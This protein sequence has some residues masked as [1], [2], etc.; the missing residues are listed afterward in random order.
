MERF[1]QVRGGLALQ[2][3]RRF[4]SS[5]SDFGAE[6]E[7]RRLTN[8]GEDIGRL[9][10][11]RPARRA[12][13]HHGHSRGGRF[14][15]CVRTQRRHRARRGS[16]GLPR[17]H[18]AAV[19]LGAAG[20]RLPDRGAPRA[21]G[22]AVPRDV[23]RQGLPPSRTGG[24]HPARDQGPLC[25]RG[26]SRGPDPAQPGR[27]TGRMRGRHTGR[28]RRGRSVRGE[29]G[30]GPARGRRGDDHR[31]V[32]AADRLRHPAPRHQ[33]R[34]RTR[35]VRR[36]GQ[37]HLPASS[38]PLAANGPSACRSTPSWRGRSRPPGS[39]PTT[40]S[41]TPSPPGAVPTGIASARPS[42]PPTVPSP[43]S[44]TGPGR[45]SARC[46]SSI[47][48]C[49]TEP[50]RR[51]RRAVVHDPVRPRLAAHRVDGAAAGPSPGARHAAD[52][53][54]VPGRPTTTRAPRRSRA[55]SCTRSAS[56]PHR[57]L[58]RPAARVYYG[59][60]R[61]HAAVRDAARR[62]A[63]V[64][65]C[66]RRAWPSCCRTPTR[67]WTGSSSYGDRD[68]DGFVEYQRDDRPRA[69]QPGLE[70]LLGRVTFADGTAR[71]TPRSRCA[72]VQGYVY[73]AYV[74]RAHF[75]RRGRRQRDGAQRWVGRAARLREAFNERLLAAGPGLVRPRPRRR[76]A[77]DRRARLQ[78]GPLPVDRDRRRGQGA[79]RSPSACS[80]RRCSPAGACAR[81][82]P[83]MG[84][85]NP[86]SYHNG[87]VWPH[88]N[89][90]IAAGLMRYGFVEEAQR[91][92][93]GLLDAADALRRPAARAV[94]R[95]RPGRVRRAGAVSHLV[96]SPGV[97]RGQ[98]HPAAADPAPLRPVHSR[99]PGVARP[100]RAGEPA[101]HGAPAGGLPGHDRRRRG[102]RRRRRAAGR[103]RR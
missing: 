89:A 16:G 90:L 22:R 78:H 69:G 77:P 6:E 12:G 99:R 27:R 45:I 28:L 86:M 103:D 21:R 36:A 65:R 46:G 80:R 34:G 14:V 17:R 79:P 57:R 38:S 35:A 72:E 49:P 37:A 40:R 84:A 67:R 82:P 60:G 74:A 83:T 24:E 73:A 95:L 15:L 10:I 9:D 85:Y 20:G 102:G 96:L 53:G 66:D 52:A 91:I 31:Q 88:D 7:A 94:L 11:R 39:P 61:R 47:R 76:Q 68:G 19:A 5:L 93:D 18:P 48:A 44:C 75:A 13:R 97:G 92:A 58:A 71:P 81:S 41:N 4:R 101:H 8:S 1:P 70:G 30:P 3:K 51:R 100:R 62:A 2:L 29:V 32:G 87:S 55:R 64:G 43:R 98:P 25:R 50:P 26:P 54:P 56:A 63:P 42:P 23:P 33:D 59:I